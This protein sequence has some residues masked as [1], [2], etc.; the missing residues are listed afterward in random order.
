MQP[1]LQKKLHNALKKSKER[2][3]NKTNKKINMLYRCMHVT[4]KEK[5]YNQSEIFAITLKKI[6]KM[7]SYKR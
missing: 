4:F 5:F 1:L 6:F 3:T 2:H 7:H